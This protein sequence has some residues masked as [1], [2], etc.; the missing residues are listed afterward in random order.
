MNN[1]NLN[2]WK[3]VSSLSSSYKK[4]DDQHKDDI[5]KLEVAN[6]T[7]NLDDIMLK[8]V[9]VAWKDTIQDGISELNN[10]KKTKDNQRIIDETVKDLNK[11]LYGLNKI[12]PQ[13]KNPSIFEKWGRQMKNSVEQIYKHPIQPNAKPLCAND[14]SI[15]KN[16]PPSIRHHIKT[17]IQKY[18]NNS[19]QEYKCCIDT[20]FVDT[21][22]TDKNI[23]I[24]FDQLESLSTL[25][26]YYNT[27]KQFILDNISEKIRRQITTIETVPDVE[28]QRK[29]QNIF[30]PF[31]YQTVFPAL[32]TL[33]GIYTSTFS[34]VYKYITNA[35]LW[36]DNSSTSK[37]FD[38]NE[39]RLIQFLNLPNIE[40]L[41]LKKLI[42]DENS[43]VVYNL[44]INHL[45]KLI[46][47]EDLLGITY[48]T[49]R[50]HSIPKCKYLQTKMTA[51]TIDLY[52][53]NQ[54]LS[55]DLIVNTFVTLSHLAHLQTL[56]IKLTRDNVKIK[57][58][59]LPKLETLTINGN[60]NLGSSNKNIIFDNS[61]IH[62]L[63]TFIVEGTITAT[64]Q[65][66][67]DNFMYE[68]IRNNKVL[69]HINID[70]K[71]ITGPKLYEQYRTIIRPSMVEKMMVLM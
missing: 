45:P 33:K 2:D 44:Y 60:I 70:G 19:L 40:N 67:I 35:N 1:V 30:I 17:L 14:E 27:K 39:Q 71:S 29:E 20:V 22:V 38:N 37:Y 26:L 21:S 16:M 3:T 11:A 52:K 12:T 41:N 64:T 42:G 68:I 10:T 69:S 9:S 43:N 36:V 66:N 32:V 24:L 18:N 5:D 8:K 62:K 25:I 56:N 55:L 53:I 59:S 31:D 57:L 13:V 63:Q 6:S 28:Q 61:S 46:L 34:F 7:G 15:C 58:I 4:F 48:D 49:I 50:I 51:N 47:F 23:K 65:E 54:I